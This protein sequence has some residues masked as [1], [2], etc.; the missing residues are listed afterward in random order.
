M[1]GVSA[2]SIVTVMCVETSW[3]TQLLT[4]PSKVD[5]LTRTVPQWVLVT[6]LFNH[7][8][9]HRGPYH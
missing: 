9:H 8:T 2:S 6:H 4:Y 5:G 7:Q 1:S 3:L